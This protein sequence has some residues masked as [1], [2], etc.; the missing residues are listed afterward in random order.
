MPETRKHTRVPRDDLDRAILAAMGDDVRALP[1][2]TAEAA[3]TDAASEVDPTSPD[4]A[5]RRT[6]PAVPLAS[7]TFRSSPPAKGTDP[8]EPQP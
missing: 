6:F 5:V 2:G 7:F 1:A 8:G 3:G 4:A